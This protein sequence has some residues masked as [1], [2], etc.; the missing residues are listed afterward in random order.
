MVIG[1]GIKCVGQ[2]TLEAVSHIKA[3]DKVLYC[4][5]DPATEQ[6]VLELNPNAMDMYVL[7]AEGKNRYQTYV[8][9]A[10]SCLYF[11]RQGLHTVVIFYGHPGVFVTPSHRCI[12]IAKKQ[13]T[14]SQVWWFTI[15]LLSLVATSYMYPQL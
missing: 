15:V 1:S 8:Q 14:F 10:E 6:Y 7:Y 5:A 12:Q 4:V 9:M 13:G 2:F 11:A 3:A